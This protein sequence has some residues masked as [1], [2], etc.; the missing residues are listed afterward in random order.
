MMERAS[1]VSEIQRNFERNEIEDGL[2]ALQEE[3]LKAIGISVS[4]GGCDEFAHLPT[5]EFANVVL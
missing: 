3:L 5:H 4:N 2:G 1:R